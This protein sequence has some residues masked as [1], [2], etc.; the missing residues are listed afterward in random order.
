MTIILITGETVQV[1]CFAKNSL[2]QRSP[3]VVLNKM[4]LFFIE[5]IGRLARMSI[6]DTEVDGSKPGS[7]MLFP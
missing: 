7:S 1:R 4:K 6:L 5:H 2:L 3:A